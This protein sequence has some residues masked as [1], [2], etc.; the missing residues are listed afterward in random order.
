MSH[1]TSLSLEQKKENGIFYT[2]EFLAN[3]TARKLIY[4]FIKDVDRHNNLSILDP[5]CGNGI[6]LLSIN[7]YLKDINVNKPR[8]FGIDKDPQSIKECHKIL[9]NSLNEK[10]FKLI[11]ADAIQPFSSACNLGWDRIQNNLNIEK[12]FD[13]A[14]SNP[15]WGADLNGYSKKSLHQDFTLANG[16]IDIFN[17]FV[18]IVLKRLKIN[19]Y[20]A[21][22]LPDSIF[23]QEKW[24]LRKLLLETTEVKLIGRLG[25]KI[26]DNVNRACTIVIG[27]KCTPTK[28]NLVDCFRLNPS[29]R[30]QIL[31]TSSNLDKAEKEL[32]HKVPQ[33]RFYNNESYLFDID[34]QD[35]ETNLIS[36]L[37]STN[38]RFSNIVDNARGA[39][40]S[41]KGN[42]TRCYNCKLY[43]PYPKA[44]IPKCPH[45]AVELQYSSLNKDQ[46]VFNHNGNGTKP[47]KSGEDLSRY[48]SFKRKWID[49]N[50]NGINYKNLNLYKGKKILVRK[51]GVGITAS[52]DYDEAITNQ[53]VYILKIQDKWKSFLTDEFVLAIL[54]SRIITY[55]LLKRYGDSEW[56]SHPYITQRM[57]ISLPFPKVKRSPNYKNIV[58]EITQLVQ[59]ELKLQQNDINFRTDAIIERKIADLFSLT[60]S[61]Y[62]LIYNQLESAEQLVPIKRLLKVTV[63]D[64]FE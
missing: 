26:F 39:E 1:Y 37:Q 14:I 22:I 34:C 42:V 10:D 63:K 32:I 31:N 25:E 41:K 13:L 47:L 9:S 30:K 61:D 43:L 55:Y 27:K 23:N 57:L 24:K 58:T 48:F 46:I 5:A 11:T 45:C 40:I 35:F 38:L 36:K 60:K 52:L 54:N 4:Y 7:K 21:L 2:P 49:V 16:Q 51:T 33:E 56:K 3:Y 18:E 12:G 8:F 59:H 19:G 15:P 20:Y 64:I 17:L 29:Y 53:V 50:K 6:L 62:Y 28:N 44:D